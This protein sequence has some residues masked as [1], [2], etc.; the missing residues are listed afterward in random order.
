MIDII[1]SIS[2]EIGHIYR[3]MTSKNSFWVRVQFIL[4]FAHR[5]IFGEIEIN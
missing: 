2:V 3:E 5:L 1:Y 4:L